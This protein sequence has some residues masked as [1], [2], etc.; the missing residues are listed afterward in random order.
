VTS[1][2]KVEIYF[3]GSEVYQLNLSEDDNLECLDIADIA[4]TGVQG[5]SCG[6][7]INVSMTLGFRQ[8]NSK[9]NFE[10]LGIVFSK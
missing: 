7:G 5:G 1:I 6:H 4:A 2:V 8:Q 9:V 3:G 10:S